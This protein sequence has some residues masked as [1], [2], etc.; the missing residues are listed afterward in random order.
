MSR[1]HERIPW[2]LKPA[3]HDEVHGVLDRPGAA[4]SHLVGVPGLPEPQVGVQG[5]RS[6]LEVGEQ[7][8]RGLGIDLSGGDV[9]VDRPP[10]RVQVGL[11]HP[12]PPPRGPV[13][14]ASH[15]GDVELAVEVVELIGGG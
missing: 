8:G 13:G 2:R 6:P 5:S 14:I 11:G 7:V 4:G 12:R 15:L 1:P 9:V 3:G 10:Q